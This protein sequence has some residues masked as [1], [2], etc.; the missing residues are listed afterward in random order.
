[1]KHPKF[2]TVWFALLAALLATA[3]ATACSTEG[4]RQETGALG[5]VRA[6][7]AMLEAPAE[8]DRQIIRSAH[9]TLEVDNL[10]AARA[11]AEQD[12]VARQGYVEA[13]HESE[14]SLT[15]QFRVPAD[16]LDDF[17]AKLHGLGKV[18]SASVNSQ[19]VT[20]QHAD[21]E[22]RLANNRKLR[23][24][25]QQLLDK[26]TTVEEMLAVEKELA[27]VQSEVES[28]QGRLDRLDSQIALSSVSLTL[29]R[30]RILGPLGWLGYGI[31]WAIE[32]LFIIR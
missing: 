12:L 11:A 4:A 7:S 20:E 27:R 26:A 2:T 9:L 17:L 8:T 32:K 6:Q 28:L 31:Y 1:M 22:V 24:R 14:Q 16:E 25:L 13:I 19:D 18:K 5:R 15:L 30:G 29:E 23:D 21:L 3:C 10:D